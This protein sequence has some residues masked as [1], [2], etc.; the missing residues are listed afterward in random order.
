MKDKE[1]K[2]IIEGLLPGVYGRNEE[3]FRALRET[4]ELYPEVAEGK[5]QNSASAVPDY[6]FAGGDDECILAMRN[7]LL[8]ISTQAAGWD[9]KVWLLMSYID[10]TVDDDLGAEG[11][12]VFLDDLAGFLGD[13]GRTAH[14]VAYSLQRRLRL[15]QWHPNWQFAYRLPLTSP[16][17]LAEQEGGNHET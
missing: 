10:K 3:F 1:V 12:S 13:L 2:K 8:E 16:V 6:I 9:K 15:G 4:G 7:I 11:A 14:L 17:E 5:K